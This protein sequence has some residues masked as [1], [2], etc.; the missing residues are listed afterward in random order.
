MMNHQYSEVWSAPAERSGDGAFLSTP[1]RIKLKALPVITLLVSL[2]ATQLHAQFG[3][4]GGGFGGFGGGGQGANANR[5]STTRTYPANGAVGDAIISV[6]PET[7]SVI[8]I[9][10]EKTREYIS[11]VVSNL[12]RPKPQ[13]LIR[14]VFLEVTHNNSLDIGIDGSYTRNFGGNFM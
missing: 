12:D 11:Q 3:P 1:V 2:F 5:R 10:D 4:G 13:V 6:D 8:V 9:A 14:V 7:R